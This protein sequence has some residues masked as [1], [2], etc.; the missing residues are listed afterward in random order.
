SS[1]CH[2]PATDPRSRSASSS[3]A[4]AT[5][6]ACID[7][8]RASFSSSAAMALTAAQRR[9]LNGAALAA[10]AIAFV[11]LLGP[12]L[13]PFAIGAVLA[14]ALHPLGEMVAAR[15]VAAPLAG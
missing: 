15:P 8:R 1:T 9:P 3:S 7:R 4:T 2:T 12:V 14:Y 5:A 11:W 10:A 13:T 6:S